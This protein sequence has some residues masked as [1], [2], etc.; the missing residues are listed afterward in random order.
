MEE[1]DNFLNNV[2]ADAFFD[3]KLELSER[4]TGRDVSA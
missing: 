3:Y 2:Y 4:D 1:G